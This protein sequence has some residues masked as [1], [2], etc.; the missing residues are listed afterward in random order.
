MRTNPLG[1]D[2]VNFNINMPKEERL[3]LG[4]LAFSQDPGQSLGEFLKKLWH[5]ALE[6]EAPEAAAKLADIRKTHRAKVLGME[7]E[8]FMVVGSA[9]LL[10]LFGCTEIFKPNDDIRRAGRRVRSSVRVF[11]GR[12]VELEAV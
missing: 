1:A 9:C 3:F 6:Q 10:L 5:K 8:T 11:A 12:R 7:K 4:R 2:S